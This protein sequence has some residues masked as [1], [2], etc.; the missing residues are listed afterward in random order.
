MKFVD[1]K[2]KE[3]DF[4]VQF[5]QVFPAHYQPEIYQLTVLTLEK[6]VVQRSEFTLSK[7]QLS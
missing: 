4:N 1:K 7:V 2:K 5:Q 3:R 6:G